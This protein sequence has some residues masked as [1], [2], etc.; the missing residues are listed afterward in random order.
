Q[1]E[2][3]IERSMFIWIRT[4]W[5]NNLGLEPPKTMADVLAISKAFTERDPD[6]NGKPDTLGLGVTKGLWGGSNGLEGFMAGYKAYP[7]IWTEDS[8]GKLQFG[9]IQPEVK[10][11][12]QVLQDMFKSGQIDKEFGIKDGGKVAED[13]TAGK[14]G[15]QI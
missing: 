9:S 6:G 8:S 7:N 11:A 14:I 15:M 1:V 2:P 4:D 13:I 12:L 10:K 5:L 3:S